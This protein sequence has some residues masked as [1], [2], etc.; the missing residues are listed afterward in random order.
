MLGKMKRNIKWLFFDLGSTLID[1]HLAYEHTFRE[2][3]M[4]VHKGYDE[5]YSEA[6]EFYKQNKKGN[7]ELIRKYQLEKGK[8]HM[9]DEI[10]YKAAKVCLQ[11][12]GSKYHI[13]IIANQAL[14]TKERLD[15]WGLLQYIDMV[16]ASTEEGISKPDLRIFQLAL[17]QAGCNPNEAIMI[18]DRIDNDIIPAKKI[19]M[20][21]IWVKQGMGSY[22]NIS[23]DDEKA[24]LVVDHIQEILQLL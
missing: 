13:G 18:G 10:P 7:L 23:K 6:I 16:I 15:K 14:G 4:Q 20:S 22:W 1:E 12:L 3:A 24:D 8:W 21:T 5:I 11:E 9:E 17:E 19:G 2:I